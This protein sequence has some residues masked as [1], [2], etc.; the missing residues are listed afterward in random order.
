MIVDL[1]GKD[2]PGTVSYENSALNL[3]AVDVPVS[4][5][6]LGDLLGPPSFFRQPSRRT[7]LRRLIVHLSLETGG[8]A[9]YTFTS[10]AFRPVGLSQCGTSISRA[11][12]GSPVGWVSLQGSLILAGLA[13]PSRTPGQCQ[14]I[15]SWSIALF[16]QAMT[17]GNNVP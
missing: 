1:A 16:L 4:Q 3:A 15:G 6:E 11:E 12:S 14:I 17:G 5:D 9:S 13:V 10:G 7:V 2:L 8:E